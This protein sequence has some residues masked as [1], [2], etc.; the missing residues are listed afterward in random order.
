MMAELSLE[1]QDRE[2]A[3]AFLK[4]TVAAYRSG[5]YPLSAPVENQHFVSFAPVSLECPVLSCRVPALA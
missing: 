2:V 4:R 3:V 5:E 1:D